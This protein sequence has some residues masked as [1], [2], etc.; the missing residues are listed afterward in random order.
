MQ[1]HDASAALEVELALV[2]LGR[3]LAVVEPVP[4]TK[5]GVGL[6][7]PPSSLVGSVSGGTIIFRGELPRT[8]S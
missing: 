4:R 7:R 1:E 8:I 2:V 5:D 6:V 3:I